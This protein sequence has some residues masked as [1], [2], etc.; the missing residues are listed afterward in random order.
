MGAVIFSYIA[1]WMELLRTPE[2][3]QN[4]VFMLGNVISIK[5]VKFC[6]S[7]LWI[8]TRPLGCLEIERQMCCYME[9]Q[10]IAN[11]WALQSERE[12]GDL[13]DLTHRELISHPKA[14]ASHLGW[15]QTTWG[16]S[17][18]EMSWLWTQQA[19]GSDGVY[20][21]ENQTEDAKKKKKKES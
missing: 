5:S 3:Q 16:C 21:V 13:G 17:S 2:S 8:T 10:D 7:G 18:W 4:I 19:L 20:G 1:L 12:G 11:C 15:R 9:Q 6:F 14:L